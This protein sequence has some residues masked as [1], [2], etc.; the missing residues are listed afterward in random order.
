MKPSLALYRPFLTRYLAH[1]RG[2]VALLGTMLLAHTVASVYAPQL[3]RGFIDGVVAGHAAEQLAAVAALFLAL[4]AGRQVSRGLTAYFS[5]SVAWSATN[6]LR[7]D[8][9]RH[10][11]G[12]DL[13]FVNRHAPGVMLERIDGDSSS[14]PSSPSSHCACCAAS[15]C[16]RGS[17]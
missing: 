8:L 13:S 5:E 11:V 14:R 16:W 6:R 17:C 12:L 10:T 7:S 15:C 4:A 3:L 9:L 2:Q 1:C